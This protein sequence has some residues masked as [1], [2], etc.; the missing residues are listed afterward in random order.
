MSSI[1]VEKASLTNGI[2]TLNKSKRKGNRTPANE[3]VQEN[4]TIIQL[5]SRNKTKKGKNKELNNSSGVRVKSRVI[6]Q[7]SL[8]NKANGTSR[9][10]RKLNRAAVSDIENTNSDTT[11]EEVLRDERI[12]SSS[13][14]SHE[15][16]KN[17][18]N[19]VN[20][21]LKLTP[22]EA[23]TSKT[24]PDHSDK[25]KFENAKIKAEETKEPRERTII[26]A[27]DQHQAFAMSDPTL[28]AIRFGEW[29][30]EPWCA[31]SY[32]MEYIANS[33]VYVCEFCL[34]YM[35]SEFIADRHKMKC[36]VRHPPGDEIYRDGPIS[37]FEVDGR[38]NKIYCQNLCLFAKMFIAH[39]TLFFDVEPFLFYVMTE[40]NDTGCHFVGYFSK[41]KR[42]Q[43]NHNVSC[44]LILPIHQRKG[45]GNLLI[46]FSYLLTKRENK[47]GS[48]EKP[49]SKSGLHSY[50]YYWKNVLFEELNKDRKHISIQELSRL[51]SMTVDDVIATLQ[52]NNMIEKDEINDTY[53]IVV[54]K[55]IVEA[56]L[57]KGLEFKIDG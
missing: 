49:L 42:S 30:I 41:E 35:R 44:I 43:G 7:R 20:F 22:E 13:D 27:E 19:K 47:I 53:K 50:R 24:R 29:E 33:L 6:R 36:P 46:E 9:N 2:S 40:T 55:R 57:Q 8:V 25:A 11:P 1:A 3:D 28:E 12:E 26:D 32:E 5:G 52:I 37:I 48:P 10:R 45:Y 14:G 39:K 15:F 31:S 18:E 23:D 4:V 51:T 34:K 21:A 54:N 56:H 16:D 17:D 38:K